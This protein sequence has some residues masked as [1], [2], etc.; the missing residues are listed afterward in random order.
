[1]IE[2]SN[3]RS[4]IPWTDS[5]FAKT[6]DKETY[7]PWTNGMSREGLPLELLAPPASRDPGR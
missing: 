5:P 4:A 3:P 6:S 1:M 2:W 7:G